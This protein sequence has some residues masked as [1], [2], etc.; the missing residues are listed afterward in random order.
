M[1]SRQNRN[2]RVDVSVELPRDYRGNAFSTF[3]NFAPEPPNECPEPEHKEE[4]HEEEKCE[5]KCEEKHDE[6]KGF[7]KKIGDFL[8]KFLGESKE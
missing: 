2:P 6:G 5:E 8:S 3:Q 4:C 7:A 1:Y